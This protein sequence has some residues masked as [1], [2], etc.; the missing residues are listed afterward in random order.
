MGA[1]C[2]LLLLSGCG[3]PA[4]AIVSIVGAGA[5]V[6]KDAVDIAVSLPP[7][8]PVPAPVVIP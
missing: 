6:A 1:L 4:A 2:V 7:P 5:L 3:L 8:A